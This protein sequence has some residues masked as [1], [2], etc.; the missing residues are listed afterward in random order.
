MNV[1][2]LSNELKWKGRMD[3]SINAVKPFYEWNLIQDIY[4]YSR[5]W[6]FRK[7]VE[8]VTGGSM[9]N[10]ETRGGKPMHPFEL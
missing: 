4:Q 2:F 8:L 5:K 1:N 7:V 9:F 3:C 10:L 6:K